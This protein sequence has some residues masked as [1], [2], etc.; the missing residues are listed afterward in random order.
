M[1]GNS[2]ITRPLQRP[3]RTVAYAAGMMAISALVGLIIIGVNSEWFDS[4]PYLFLMPWICVL[5]IVL[6]IPVGITLA[7]G[8]NGLENPLMIATI[9]YFFP[10]FVI[11]GISLSVG[12]SDPYYLSFIQDSRTDLPYTVVIIIAGFTGLAVGYLSPPGLFLG[13]RL[14]SVLPVSSRTSESYLVP[15]LI[16]LILGLMNSAYASAAGV[17]GYQRGDGIGIY[18]GIIFLSTL[19]LVEGSFILWWCIFSQPR[20]TLKYTLV[21]ILLIS[22]SL[23]TALL[24]G[25]RGSLFSSAILVIIAYLLTGRKFTFKRMLTTGL[26]FFFAVILGMIYGTTFRE[27]KGSE[28]RVDF[29]QYVGSIGDTMQRIAV[30]DNLATLEYGLTN[31]AQRLDIVSSVAVVVS[32]HEQL[33][34]YEESYGLDNNIWKDTTNFFIPR[35]IWPDKPLASDPRAFSDL[36]FNFGENSFAITPIGDLVRNFGFF[37]VLAGMLLL[38]FVLRIIYSA[39]VE[40]QPRVLWRVTLY[41]MLVSSVS[42]E[43]FYGSILPLLF[44][45]GITATIG[46]IIVE[47]IAQRMPAEKNQKQ[48]V[49]RSRGSLARS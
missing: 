22:V 34:P 18:D 21:A 33:A 44:K 11:G 3:D 46:L 1:V 8:G 6:S 12:L 38:G 17:I 5:A 24:A 43:A 29:D 23:A 30:R 42:Y 27:T 28:A 25:N 10:A 2:G 40:D 15:G 32:N 16:L 20:I 45:I 14:R 13:K 47:V 39:L 26:V 9:T 31:L 37:G 41:F 49:A 35:V 48:I 36:Y 7:R 4:F 19:F